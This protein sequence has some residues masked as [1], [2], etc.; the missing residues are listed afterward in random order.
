MNKLHMVYFLGI[1]GIGMSALARYF[2]SKGIN[3]SGYDKTPT[4]ITK[5]LMDDGIKIHFS[6]NINLIPPDTDL[7]NYTP[8]IPES[9]QEFQYFVKNKFDLKKRSEILGQITHNKFTIAVAGT[10]GKTTI[11]SIIAHILKS[12]GLEVTALVGGI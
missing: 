5:E 1:G 7:V 10:H 3:V 12:N 11:S 8:A 9:N 4:F 6:E 2:H